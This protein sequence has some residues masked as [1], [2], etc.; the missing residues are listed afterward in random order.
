MGARGPVRAGLH[1]GTSA[2]SGWDQLHLLRGPQITETRTFGSAVEIVAPVRERAGARVLGRCYA[3]FGPGRPVSAH[4]LRSMAWPG[5]WLLRAVRGSRQNAALLTSGCLVR[6]ASKPS[7]RGVILR[8]PT[9][10]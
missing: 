7:L 2:D 10:D 8:S 9:S 1:R 6:E 3:I 4:P 5:R